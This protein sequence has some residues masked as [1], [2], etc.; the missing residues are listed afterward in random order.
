M[1]IKAIYPG[2][3]DPIT[4]GHF[5]L[6]EPIFWGHNHDAVEMFISPRALFFD[7]LTDIFLM[8]Y[9]TTLYRI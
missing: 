9:I 5:D 4:N 7:S 3:F 6:I 2:T 8:L 1:S